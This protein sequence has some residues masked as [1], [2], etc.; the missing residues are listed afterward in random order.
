MAILKTNE[1]KELEVEDNGSI[2]KA[3]REFDVPFGCENGVCGSCQVEVFEGEENLNELNEL[4]KDMGLDRKHRLC[5]QAKI[6][7]G[8]VT[9]HV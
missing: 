3:A 5:C 6:K 9:I 1:G 8:S 7:E 4:E 2:I